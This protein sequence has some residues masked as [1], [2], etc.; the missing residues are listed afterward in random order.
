MEEEKLKKSAALYAETYA[1]DREIKELTDFA[2]RNGPN[3][4]CQRNDY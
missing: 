3:E 1:E 4:N 2:L